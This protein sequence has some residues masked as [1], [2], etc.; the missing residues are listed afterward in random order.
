VSQQEYSRLFEREHDGVY[1]FTEYRSAGDWLQSGSLFGWHD[2][3]AYAV[4]A[5]YRTQNGVRPNEDLES[6]TLLASLKVQAA[7]NDE[8]YFE[9]R[10]HEF[11]SGDLL[12]YEDPSRAR[13]RL[14]VRERQEPIVALGYQHRWSDAWRT[15]F[16]FSRL[17]DTLH[18]SDIAAP[19]VLVRRNTAGRLTGIP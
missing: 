4:D 16:L 19:Q 7:R 9:I 2:R 12:Q 18:L 6:R 14:R 5:Y 11:E 10:Q 3:F 15:L 8:V 17:D 13:T 1:S